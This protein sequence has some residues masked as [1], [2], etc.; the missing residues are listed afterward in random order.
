MQTRIVLWGANAT[1]ERVM[2]ALQLRAK[3][4]QVDLYTFP[5]AL[6]TDEFT[7]TMMNEW[8]KGQDPELPG[9]KT[10]EVRDLSTA[11]SLL[12]DTLKVT[13]DADLLQ[14]AQSEWPF[15]VLSH[16]LKEAY[17]SE[18]SELKD[19]VQR[20]EKYDKGMWEELKAFWGKVQNQVK[21]KTMEWEQAAPLRKTTDSL[22]DSMKELRKKM[23]VEFEAAS[24]THWESFK[25]KLDDVDKKISEG[26]RLGSVFEELKQIQNK[27]KGVR[28]TSKHRNELWDRLNK[29]FEE[30]KAK[31]FG[32]KPGGQKSPSDRTNRRYEGLIR[33][34]EKMEKSIKYDT[35]ELDFQ[36][37]RIATT[38]GQL[39]AQIRQA[40]IRM[41]QERVNSKKEKLDDML[42]TK[43]ELESK[44]ASQKAKE[45]K[46]AKEAAAKAKIAEEMK[47]KE[48][49]R[50]AEATK[51]EEAA[52]K[53]KDGKAK[54]A[55]KAKAE[56]PKEE[57]PK[58][59]APKEEESILS[60]AAATLGDVLEDAV[61]T[62]KAVAEVVGGKIE[63]AVEEL[64]ESLNEEEE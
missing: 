40:K 9:E 37:K 52:D 33:A 15:M 53:I 50:A 48:A 27:F 43:G 29:S 56:A 13:K 58:A 36:N 2:I 24:A 12:P 64:K 22:F 34:I 35:N 51:L 63:E 4:N 28:M 61:D 17:E 11:E 6:L 25:T 10:H 41:I 30:V 21:E 59:E 49:A 23:D 20:L 55:P 47:A 5:D 42:K 32:E 16:K 26:L 39:E 3:D 7:A 57:A 18:L 1:D 62:V 46:R 14:R 54:A 31:R 60:A 45:E 38:D 19:R 8:R 44:M